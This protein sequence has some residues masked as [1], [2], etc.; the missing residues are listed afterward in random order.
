MPRVKTGFTRRR[1]HKKILKKTKG[2]WGSRGKLYRIAHEAF[3]RAGEHA[4]KG[5]RERKRD[6]RRLWIQRIN[7]GLSQINVKYGVFMHK[8]VESKIEL[9]RKMLSEL[10]TRDIDTF[11][12]VVEKVNKP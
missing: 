3:M 7:A 4:F 8:L 9:N 1:R 5:R 6:F 10:A 2:Y 11:K 12:E